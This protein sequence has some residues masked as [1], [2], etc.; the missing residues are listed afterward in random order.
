MVWSPTRVKLLFPMDLA[1]IENGRA[2]LANVSKSDSNAGRVE[3]FY[4]GNWGAVCGVGWDLI[5]AN[6]LCLQLGLGRA[7][8]VSGSA[9]F[10]QGSGAV[11]LENVSCVGNERYLSDCPSAGLRVSSC[12]HRYDAGVVCG[13]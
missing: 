13:E 4:N 5:D 6:V 2:R 12:S 7:I 9:A 3:V 1:A 8:S 11:A 10:G